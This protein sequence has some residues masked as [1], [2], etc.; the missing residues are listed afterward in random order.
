M[1]IEI[2]QDKENTLLDR[3]EVRF[4]VYYSGPTPDRM[5]VREG[6]IRKLGCDPELTVLDKVESEQGRTVASGYL[7]VYENIQ[8]MVIEPEHKIKRNQGKQ[9]ETKEKAP[10]AKA[11][12]LPKL[13]Y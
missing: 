2:I 10:K 7:K 12:E 6:L 1:E 13:C 8:A 3:R 11:E 9:E 5:T 4:K